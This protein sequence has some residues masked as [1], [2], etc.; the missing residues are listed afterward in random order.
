MRWFGS[1]DP[2]ELRVAV[3]RYGERAGCNGVAFRGG[4]GWDVGLGWDGWM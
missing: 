2:P 4:G 3:T 1:S